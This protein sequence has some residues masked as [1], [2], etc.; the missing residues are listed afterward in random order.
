VHFPDPQAKAIRIHAVLPKT[1][2]LTIDGDLRPGNNGDFTVSLQKLDLP[3]FSPYAMAAGASLD[4]GQA[5]IKTKVK[6]R[7]TTMQ[8]DNELVL[9]KF[10]VSMRDPSTF[11][12]SFG[13]PID[14]V[15][16][17]LRDP[18][19][20]IKL[21]IPVKIDDKGAEVSTGAI[22]ASALKAALLGALTSPLKLLGGAFEGAQG[23]VGGMFSIPAIKSR[24][25]VAE[26]DADA[27]ARLDSVAKLLS[28]RPTM[29][30]T[31]RGRTGPADM[32]VVAEQVLVERIKNGKG[33]P[34]VEGT[35]I[36]VRRRISQ[37]LTARDKSGAAKTGEAPA[38]SAED[39]VVFDRCIAAAEVEPSRLDALAK[40]RAE[41]VRDLLVAKAI[42]AA[43]VT[44]GEREA[45]GDPGVVIS[46]RSR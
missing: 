37:A 41:K 6:M 12:R 22:I 38:L 29:G 8:V 14:L 3:V 9:R 16:A 30:L 21:K 34:D 13:M 26:P 45:D 35:G 43:R 11:E 1:S 27:S 15:L 19:G 25:G 2:V 4:A 42:D 40:S 23:M 36:L 7:G 10:G 32:P 33:L 24:A 18:S 17:L 20:D 5:S 46:L 28:E 39:K 44:V 31:L